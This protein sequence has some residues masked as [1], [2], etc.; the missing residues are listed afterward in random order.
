[1][2]VVCVRTAAVDVVVFVCVCV[3]VCVCVFASCSHH[4]VWSHNTHQ[5]LQAAQDVQ[6]KAG[7]AESHARK[8]VT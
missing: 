4:S 2:H 7:M 8:E 5:T 1:M 6:R 3:C